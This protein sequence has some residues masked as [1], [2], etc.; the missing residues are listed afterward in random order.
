MYRRLLFN[1]FKKKL[2]ISFLLEYIFI[3]L[4]FPKRSKVYDG[5]R[6]RQ[7]VFFLSAFVKMD[8]EES[9]SLH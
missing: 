9:L 2:S 6:S 8:Q 7:R 4:S 5:A 3:I 1:L